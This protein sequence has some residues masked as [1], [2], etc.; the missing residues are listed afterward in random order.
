MTGER[1]IRPHAA[2]AEQGPPIVDIERLIAEAAVAYP[3]PRVT[4]HHPD[5]IC[6]TTGILGDCNCRGAVYR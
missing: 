2:P 6:H 4:F 5:C 3:Q 1:P